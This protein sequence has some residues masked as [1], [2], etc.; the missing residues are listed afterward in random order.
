MGAGKED[1]GQVPLPGPFPQCKFLHIAA[2]LTELN[3]F[4][5]L[6]RPV[7]EPHMNRISLKRC[8]SADADS[9]QRMGRKLHVLEQQ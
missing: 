2:F 1:K 8:A 5:F 4:L 7:I 3:D 9:M 6:C